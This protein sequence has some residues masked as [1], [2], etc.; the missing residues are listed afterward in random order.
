MSLSVDTTLLMIS[1]DGA[2]PLTWWNVAIAALMLL[3]AVCVSSALRLRLEQ[4][5]IVAGARCFIQLTVLGLVLK[6][7]FATESPVYVLAMA[8]ALGGLAAMEVSRWR[9][10]RTVKGLFWIAFFS[11]FGSAMLVGLVGATFAMN[12][13]PP[14]KASLFIPVLGMILSNSMIGVS[15]GT[16]SVLASVDT[17]RDMLESVLCFGASRWE[18][19]R[20]IAAEAART[21]MLPSITSA[22]ITG[23]IAIPGMMSGQILSGAKVMDAARYQQVI[24]FL[25]MASVALGT[26]VSVIMVSFVVIDAQPKLRPE[27]IHLRAANGNKNSSSSSSGSIGGVATPRSGLSSRTSTIVHLKKW[28]GG[29]ASGDERSHCSV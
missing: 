11:I 24:L 14:L 21:A 13:D 15:L 12:F 25:I 2:I 20:P 8:G 9:S 26:A 22:S 6:R 4:Q 1:G 10:K 29:G 3:V 23:L 16:D 5:I 19:V 17:R 7:V 18:A 28:K 27:L